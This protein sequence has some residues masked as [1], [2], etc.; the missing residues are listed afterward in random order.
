MDLLKLIET[1]PT[2][3]AALHHLEHV[4]WKGNPVC[5]YCASDR[6][7]AFKNEERFKCRECKRSFSVRVGTIF[8][9]TRMDIRKWFMAVALMMNAKKGI[10]ALQLS[11]D[12]HCTYKSAWY[13]GMRIRCAMAGHVEMLHGIVQADTAFIG[14]KPAKDVKGNKIDPDHKAGSGTKKVKIF[15]AVEQGKDGKVVAQIIPDLTTQTLLKTLKKYVETGDT[16]LMTDAT[17]AFKKAE[18]DYT[19]LV[20]NHSKEFANSQAN[21]NKIEGFFGLLKRGHFGQYHQLSEKY[22]PFYLAEFTYRY[23]ER[24]N[25][26]SFEK[27]IQMAVENDKCMLHYKCDPNEKVEI[28]SLH[29]CVKC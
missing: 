7:T 5:P 20:V 25:K 14:G 3:D 21:L 28:C 23:N 16:K 4:R 2:Q 9:D 13:A 19:H 26:R 1:Y 22:L 17:P 6:I 15:G 27:T 12:V 8:E 11:R 29:E 18:A 24:M 10:S